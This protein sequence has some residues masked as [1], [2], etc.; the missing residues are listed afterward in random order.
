MLQMQKM[1]ATDFEYRHQTLLHLLV[2]GL[3]F[4]TY[5][6][7]PDDIV[8]ALVKHHTIY[9]TLLERIVFGIGALEIL[10]SAGL[11]TWANAYRLTAVN[12]D[13]LLASG[14]VY[15]RLENLIYVGRLLF[16]SGIGL[17]APISG[18]VILLAG[19]VALVVRLRLRNHDG[20]TLHV[21]GNV[22]KLG[23]SAIVATISGVSSP[24]FASPAQPAMVAIT[25]FTPASVSVGGKATA[26][27]SIL[28]ANNAPI[29]NALLS[30][31]SLAA[32]DPTK[33]SLDTGAVM[34]TGFV[35]TATGLAATPAAGVNVTATW[36]DGMNPVQSGAVPLVVTGP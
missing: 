33:I 7:Q 9:R 6:F 25:A 4:L 19:E 32:D 8:W 29:S 3:A 26:V 5:A 36:T 28:D 11:Q 30:Q 16:A 35:F 20:A 23:T 22:V 13:P 10:G 34:G 14:G 31:V 27:V 12:A 1:R 24:P 21:T 18:T 2:V 17:L 15:R